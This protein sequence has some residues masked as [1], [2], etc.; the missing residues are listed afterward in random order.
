MVKFRMVMVACYPKV[1]YN[2]IVNQIK[3]LDEKIRVNVTE[4]KWEIFLEKMSKGNS[5][6]KQLSIFEIMTNQPSSSLTSAE[7]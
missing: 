2:E 7:N 4:D 5:G 3:S 1:M 6:T